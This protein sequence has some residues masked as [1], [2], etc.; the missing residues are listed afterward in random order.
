MFRGLDKELDALPAEYRSHGGLAEAA[1]P[2][3]VFNAQ[4]APAA[5]SPGN[6]SLSCYT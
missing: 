6:P 5:R 2:L 1:V 4:G 3:V